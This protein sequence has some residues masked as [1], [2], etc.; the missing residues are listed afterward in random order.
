MCTVTYIPSEAGYF[1]TSNRDEK[2]TRSKAIFPKSYNINNV[3][4]IFPKD[5]DAGGTWIALKENGDSVCLLNGA[6]DN[7]K[8]KG[9]YTISRGKIVIEIIT[10]DNL[11]NAFKDINLL[12]TAPF[13]LIVVN[14]KQLFECRWDGEKKYCKALDNAKAYIWSSATLYDKATQQKREHWFTQFLLH[15]NT[16]TQ[17][18]LFKFH[19]TTGDGDVTN[20]LLMNRNEQ[21]FTVSITGIAVGK[22]ECNMY[23]ED[24]KNNDSISTSFTAQYASI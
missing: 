6:F 7:F 14:K 11:I 20:D 22:K 9:N 1:L 15:N 19:T 16:P 4:L 10:A 23:Y 13:T 3:K 8:D 12:A 5:A 24:L 2:S 21:Y 17:K 18:D